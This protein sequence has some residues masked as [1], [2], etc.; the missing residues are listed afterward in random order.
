VREYTFPT[1]VISPE[2][3]QEES[4]KSLLPPLM[5]KF[6]K[7]PLSDDSKVNNAYNILLFAYGQ[8]GTGKLIPFSDLKHLYHKRKIKVIGEYFQ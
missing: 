5:E 1:K 6:L 2:A 4:Y 7:P 3:S 8:T